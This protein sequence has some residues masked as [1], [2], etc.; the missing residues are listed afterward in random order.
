MLLGWI[1]FHYKYKIFFASISFALTSMM[2]HVSKFNLIQLVPCKRKD[3]RDEVNDDN[4][5]IGDDRE[6]LAAN[7]NVGENFAIIT[8][9]DNNESD[10]FWIFICEESL[11]MVEDD[12]L[13]SHGVKPT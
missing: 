11:V 10:D 6:M 7:L 2:F 3:V 4:C 13:P 12:A 1:E 9:K 8:I 5:L